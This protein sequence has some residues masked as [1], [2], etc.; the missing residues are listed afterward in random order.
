M[1]PSSIGRTSA[2]VR[3]RWEVLVPRGNY[4]SR[5]YHHLTM[6]LGRLLALGKADGCDT[7]RAG[8]WKYPMM[9]L[10]SFQPVG[11]TSKRMPLAGSI[12]VNGLLSAMARLPRAVSCSA[13]GL[14]RKKNACVAPPGR[15]CPGNLT[16]TCDVAR[17]GD[18]AH[19]RD[20]A[21][22]R[23]HQLPT[24][25]ASAASIWHVIDRPAPTAPCGLRA[26]EARR[27]R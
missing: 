22:H 14:S 20:H 9:P 26:T 15:Y 24:S 3:V 21:D 19:Q 5:R 6:L 17:R 25:G 23:I 18:V 10:T 2:D 7:G 11:F 1:I 13:T 16:P 8:V 12:H 27:P 4:C